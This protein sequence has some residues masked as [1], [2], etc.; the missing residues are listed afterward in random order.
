MT[1]ILI[2]GFFRDKTDMSYLEQS[3][4][5]LGYKTH[6]VNL[7]TTFGSFKEI[8]D[9]LSLQLKAFK[10][11]EL[12][13]VA[14]SMGGLVARRYIQTHLDV[15]VRNSV[16]IATPH[17]GSELADVARF[18]LPPIVSFILKPLKKLR[19]QCNYTPFDNKD[20][21]LGLIAGDK[22]SDLL[23][24]MLMPKNS[25]GR[26]SV[27]SV[28]TNDADDFIVLPFNHDEIHKKEPTINKILHFLENGVFKHEER[29]K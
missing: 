25:D 29:D 16:F 1:I 21:K 27:D 23:G 8:V 9:S 14:H 20:F 26:V 4:T 22:N 5:S 18:V 6:S 12:S 11:E 3:L 7:P 2:H 24:K 19:T 10:E 17:Y 15:E 13:F 28:K